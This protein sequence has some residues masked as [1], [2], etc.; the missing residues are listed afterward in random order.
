MSRPSVII[1]SKSALAASSQPQS[2]KQ[3]PSPGVVRAESITQQVATELRN[4]MKAVQEKI[5][6]DMVPEEVEECEPNL[7]DYVKSVQIS[8][9]AEDLYKLAAKGEL[10]AAKARIKGMNNSEQVQAFFRCLVDF[11]LETLRHLYECQFSFDLIDEK[12]DATLLDFSLSFLDPESED[13]AG[14]DFVSYL[15]AR[16]NTVCLSTCLFPSSLPSL[17]FHALLA[18]QRAGEAGSVPGGERAVHVWSAGANAIA[19]AR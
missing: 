19:R 14:V 6:A 9:P 2:S 17:L 13:D 5:I 15:L 8:S 18:V 3:S 16:S 10:R 7:K 4:E 12:T 1:T 11:D